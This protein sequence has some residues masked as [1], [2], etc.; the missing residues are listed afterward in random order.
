MLNLEWHHLPWHLHGI[1]SSMHLGLQSLMVAEISA[2]VDTIKAENCYIKQSRNDNE[3]FFRS[4][5]KVLQSPRKIDFREVK[6]ES[7]SPILDLQNI[8]TI[9]SLEDGSFI[10]FTGTVTSIKPPTAVSTGIVQEV[11]VVDE[12]SS[13][14]LSVWES[15]IPNYTIYP[16]RATR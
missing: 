6:L 9:K 16:R 10:N 2:L 12:S 7:E 8:N 14:I 15:F 5:M 3:I 1:E 13:N 11:T 4:N